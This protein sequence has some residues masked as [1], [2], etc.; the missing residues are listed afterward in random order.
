MTEPKELKDMTP[1]EVEAN[2]RENALV[3]L[4]K[5]LAETLI[6]AKKNYYKGFP[7]VGDETYDAM[8]SALKVLCPAHPVLSAVGD[9][10]FEETWVS[11]TKVRELVKSSIKP[12]INLKDFL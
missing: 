11:V 9:P 5:S 10:S 7:T 6:Y 12:S 2:A 3:F 1:E 8:E 4:A